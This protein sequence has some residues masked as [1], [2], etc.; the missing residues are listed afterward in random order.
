MEEG[1]SL[2]QLFPS[3]LI[4]TDLF[5]WV[6]TI[7]QTHGYPTHCCCAIIETFSILYINLKGI[8]AAVWLKNMLDFSTKVLVR[9]R[10]GQSLI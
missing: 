3:L 2:L 5:W 1:E 7:G 4:L 6:K 10:E 8:C 9:D